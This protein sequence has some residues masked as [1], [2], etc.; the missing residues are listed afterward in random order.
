VNST[1]I[2]GV[3]DFPLIQDQ[4]LKARVTTLRSAAKDLLIPGLQPDFTDHSINHSDSVVEYCEKL[5]E[6]IPESNQLTDKEAWLLYASCYLHDIG[7]F[8]ENASDMETVRVHGWD[9]VW[10][11]FSREDKAARLRDI[12][13]ELSSELI[14]KSHT[15]AN[16]PIAF[17]FNDYDNPGLIA[18][19]CLSHGL[20][21][22]SSE[23]AGAVSDVAGIR[24]RLLS[25][26]LRCADILD[27]SRRRANPYSQRARELPIS[28]AIHWWRHYYTMD[29]V[30]VP[31]SHRITFVFDFPETERNIYENVIP[32]IQVPEIRKEFHRHQEVF[33]SANLVFDFEIQLVSTVQSSVQSMPD[34]VFIAMLRHHEGNVEAEISKLKSEWNETNQTRINLERQLGPDTQWYQIPASAKAYSSR[35]IP[36][37]LR[38]SAYP[39]YSLFRHESLANAYQ[40]CELRA[41][42]QLNLHDNAWS[43]EFKRYEVTI[44][45]IELLT[46]TLLNFPDQD[47]EGLVS[48]AREWSSRH[49]LTNPTFSGLN[50][51]VSTTEESTIGSGMAM[52]APAISCLLDGLFIATSAESNERQAVLEFHLDRARSKRRMPLGS[53]RSSSAIGSWFALCVAVCRAT[54]ARAIELVDE[55]AAVDF[56]LGL[57]FQTCATQAHPGK[58]INSLVEQTAIAFA[59]AGLRFPPFSIELD[60]GALLATGLSGDH[61]EKIDVI[62]CNDFELFA[63]FIHPLLRNVTD[64]KLKNV[65][66]N[67]LLKGFLQ[68]GM[69]MK[70]DAWKCSEKTVIALRPMLLSEMATLFPE[71]NRV[72]R[73]DE[74]FLY[75]SW[76]AATVFARLCG[77]RLPLPREVEDLVNDP[78]LGY[79]ILD[80]SENWLSRLSS[81]P[82][83]R[84]EWLQSEITGQNGETIVSKGYIFRPDGKI[85][86]RLPT[87]MDILSV[88]S[89]SSRAQLAALRLC[90]DM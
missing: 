73:A 8:Y 42:N 43:S 5:C 40:T 3:L 65:V 86:H 44:L 45:A 34:T 33:G 20:N 62:A 68:I 78:V 53:K 70:A 47:Q 54:P 75:S 60:R 71:A 25:G 52:I 72:H 12:H 50:V 55:A 18:A 29:C 74:V 23:Y 61:N 66:P 87:Q 22:E 51:L 11:S 7:M 30:V 77:G 36:V 1:T 67:Y 4:T 76:T 49:W 32:A 69:R 89:V 21:S 79:E 26:L 37:D 39:I 24:I 81:E 56:S 82:R 90:F 31:R 63:H 46:R 16:P 58:R 83:D 10:S 84:T 6:A 35:W 27:E 48:F 57:D 59:N 28:S 14:K 17:R 9:S 2:T 13:P 38:G 19:L 64:S 85:R 80:E 88:T 15:C 41:I